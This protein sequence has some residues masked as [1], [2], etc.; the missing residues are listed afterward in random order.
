MDSILAKLPMLVYILAIS[1]FRL[2]RQKLARCCKSIILVFAQ[3][4]ADVFRAGHPGNHM[5]SQF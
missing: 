2:E 5:L 3:Y 1:V 4:M